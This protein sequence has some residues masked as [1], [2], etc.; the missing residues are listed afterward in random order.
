MAWLR[1]QPRDLMVAVLTMVIIA[2]LTSI[3]T[4][5][6][7][8]ASAAEAPVAPTTTAEPAH[9]YVRDEAGVV[10]EYV[11]V[12]VG[13]AEGNAQ[14]YTVLTTNDTPVWTVE[15]RSGVPGENARLLST[16]MT[17]SPDQLVERDGELYYV[18][19]QTLEAS[20]ATYQCVQGEICVNP[21]GGMVE[22]YYV[23]EGYVPAGDYS[24]TLRF[25]N[26]AAPDGAP[27][28]EHSCVI[29]A[30]LADDGIDQTIAV[31]TSLQDG[32]YVLV[33]GQ[34]YDESGVEGCMDLDHN[35]YA[36]ERVY[37]IYYRD[38]SDAEHLNTVI[39]RIDTV[40]DVDQAAAGASLGQTIMDEAN[41][42]AAPGTNASAGTSAAKATMLGG[43]IAGLSVGGCALFVYFLFKKRREDR[44]WEDESEI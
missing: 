5:Q 23:P 38:V 3:S 33:P 1:R 14:S 42:L 35:Y 28:E 39:T 10:R 24:I 8:R 43:L 37:T 36:P 44:D 20:D 13:P 12:D 16:K 31:P 11:L 6:V 2:L 41:P 7:V 30:S 9:I 21:S 25:M 34:L 15:C 26:I 22:A 29:A 17:V 18:P 19:A 4:L 40:Y 32:A 27:I